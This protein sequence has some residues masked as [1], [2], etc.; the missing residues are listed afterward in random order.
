MIAPSVLPTADFL[1]VHF[2]DLTLNNQQFTPKAQ[3]DLSKYVSTTW[4]YSRVLDRSEIPWFSNAEN[5]A[6]ITNLPKMTGLSPAEFT[7]CVT[8]KFQDMAILRKK[9]NPI[10]ATEAVDM[11]CHIL[12]DGLDCIQK[13]SEIMRLEHY[14]FQ[15]TTVWLISINCLD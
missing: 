1:I 14:V 7:R 11:T 5:F 8:D 4:N 15:D 2:A 3:E 6:S 12:R 10:T 9:K 13:L